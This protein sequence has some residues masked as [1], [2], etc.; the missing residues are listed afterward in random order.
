MTASLEF[1][2]LFDV[3]EELPIENDVHRFVLIGHR[4]LAIREADDAQTAGCQGKS[5]PMEEPFFVG[6][7]VNNG[8]SHS[9]DEFVRHG[10]LSA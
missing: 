2:T 7:T 3:I 1:R 4:L 10:A 8:T 5:G 9:P 6:S